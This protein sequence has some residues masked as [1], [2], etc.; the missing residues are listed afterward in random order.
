[1]DG[2]G[3]RVD[4]LIGGDG[5]EIVAKL[6]PPSFIGLGHAGSETVVERGRGAPDQAECD[7]SKIVVWLRQVHLFRARYFMG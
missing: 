6:R 4:L 7:F 3:E 1:L 5:I 2:T